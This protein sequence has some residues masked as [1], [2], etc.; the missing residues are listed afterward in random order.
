MARP[1][2]PRNASILSGGLVWH[3]ALVALLFLAAT[4]GIF[5]YA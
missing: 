3:V 1:P 4:F 5:T 2:R